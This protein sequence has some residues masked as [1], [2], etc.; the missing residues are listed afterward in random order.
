MVLVVE[1]R[2]EVNV[3]FLFA[4]EFIDFLHLRVAV[5]I[6]WSTECRLPRILHV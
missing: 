3:V 4:D 1:V 5:W 6:A 2:L